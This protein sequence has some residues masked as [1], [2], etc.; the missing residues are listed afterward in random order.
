M[1]KLGFCGMLRICQFDMKFKLNGFVTLCKLQM[2]NSTLFICI[3][4]RNN[5]MHVCVL[6]V[7]V[8]AYI[9]MYAY[10]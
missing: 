8:H 1:K 10:V 2:L 3:C 5:R 9:C 6:Y 4:K 7:C